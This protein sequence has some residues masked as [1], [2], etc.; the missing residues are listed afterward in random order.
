MDQTS[1][2]KRRDNPSIPDSDVSRPNK[3]SLSSSEASIPV[4]VEQK[5]Q[6]LLLFQNRAMKIR[7]E[8]QK[9]EI[10]DRELK[11]KGLSNKLH[12]Y[13][14]TVSC[15]CRVWDQLNTGLHILLSRVNF[16]SN[17]ID[18]LIPKG[19][20]S[21][22]FQFLRSYITE[23]PPVEGAHSIEQTL[24]KRIH[25]TQ[26][27]FT[28][29]SEA[30]EREHILSNAVIRLL[31]SSSTTKE[32]IKSNDY[33]NLLK[34]DNDKL[35]KQNQFIQSI[36]DKLQIQHK[37]LSD[38]QS[39]L[40]EQTV[41][42]QNNIKDLK[43]ELEKSN[44]ELIIERK[45]VIKLQDETL[46][47]APTVKIPS[48]SLSSNSLLNGNNSNNSNNGQANGSSSSSNNNSN[49]IISSNHNT[50]VDG[51]IIYINGQTLDE[52][53]GE[54]TKQSD[55]RLGEARKLREE[56]ANLLKELQQ[57]Q[58]DIR[59]I[60]EE[61]ILNSMPYQILRQRLQ[62]VSDEL[63]IH[64]NQCS[65]LQNDLTQFNISRRLDREALETFELQ[66]RQSLERR[67]SQLEGESVEL[68]SEKEKL[69]NLI[70]QRN[71]TISQEY[72]AESRL[73][74]DTKD[75]D[76]KKL[77]TEVVQLKADIEK[78]KAPKEE[79]E[80]AKELIQRDVHS[81]NIEI[82]ELLDKLKTTTQQNDEL[83]LIEKK[84]LDREKELLINLNHLNTQS[85]NN[86]E[87]N[88]NN[89]NNSNEIVELKISESKL[90]EELVLLKSK[91]T[92][93]EQGK[94][95]YQSEI[96][97]ISLEFKEKIKQLDITIAASLQIQESQKQEI[98]ALIM[99]ID[100]MGKAYE[101]MQEQN[102]RLIKQ[103]SDK[104]DTH[105]LLMAENIK[106]QQTIR[107]SKEAQIAM[108]DKL[109]RNEEK[110]KNQSEIM[111]KIEEKSNI[112]QKQ[113]S[114]VTE[115]LQFCNFEL[116]KHK[117]FVRENSGHNVELKTQLDH[118]GILNVELKKKADDS[119]FA[120][121]REI[122][123]AKRLDEEKQL[124][125]KKLEKA[126]SNASSSSSTAEEELRLV[127]QKLRC[128]ICNDRQK[129]TVIAKC[130]HVFCKECIYS[131][132]DTRK[133]RCPGCKRPFSESDVHP[134]YL[135]YI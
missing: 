84:L 63:D 59:I 86:S 32:S 122:D 57:L 70:D 88:D 15:L 8:E 50:R 124:L 131:N 98:E 37:Q 93:L 81:K 18:E 125:K 26:N 6:N 12:I 114:K 68:K 129:N 127:N 76:I 67:I 90:K 80:K 58:I 89:N 61:R 72:V 92:E 115:E 130:F 71:P 109:Q 34:E 62:L 27:V 99:E 36:Y 25:K 79:I 56:K 69:I 13:E 75:Q 35:S 7:V 1:D 113:L 108:E 135:D 60:P 104:E 95:K 10:N 55:G 48:P 24:Q 20:S 87:N 132:I 78:Y 126:S 14:E 94:D 134:I 47:T 133:R 64:R 43:L 102:T 49:T 42:Y 103:I 120:L 77:A 116:E 31:K 96:D 121:E 16:D 112:L 54:L 65:K 46:R 11:I 23:P 97:N 53:V 106:A 45:R 100:S 74:L 117:R 21:E 39:L 82:K 107:L 66:R 28:K 2:L 4:P 38:Q 40:T 105:A 123:K 118:L 9:L 128:S 17:M 44:D 19:Y 41:C 83:K 91:L 22:S 29:I 85:N 5:D 52:Y 119:I 110:L 111:I 101:N 30:I 73:L 51:S 33:D 3:R